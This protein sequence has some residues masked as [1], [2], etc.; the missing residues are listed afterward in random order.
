M[1]NIFDKNFQ[2]I[3]TENSLTIEPENETEKKLLDE[4][5]KNVKNKVKNLSKDYEDI[6]NIPQTQ[7]DTLTIKKGCEEYLT[8]KTKTT[9]EKNIIKLKQMTEYLK[10]YFGD[11]KLIKQITPIDSNNFRNFLL[12]VPK[13]YK[14]QNELKDKN[15]KVLIEK[16]SKI[17][18]KY[19]KQSLRTVDEVIKRV[20]SIF[21]YFEDV[22]Y[23]YKNPFVKVEKLKKGKKTDWK[24]FNKRELKPIFK[25]M[26]DNN[27]NEEFNFYKF[28]LMT[29]TRRG[30]ILD[31]K[32]K[33]IDLDKDIID[34]EGTKTEFSKRIIPIHKDLKNTIIK[35]ME[36]K[37][38]NDYLFFDFDKKLKSRVEK[39]GSR[40]NKIIIDVLGVENKKGLNIHS[41]RKNFS[42]EIFLSDLF[43]EID[44]KTIIG[45]STSGDITDEHYLRGKR[46]YK[47]YKE[48]IDKIDFKHYYN[49]KE[50]DLKD[51]NNILNFI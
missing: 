28:G 4:I 22:G 11:K 18:E 51:L 25:Y 7:R 41:L 48:K 14:G 50:N 35:Q 21:N 10:L 3:R 13:N 46:N 8:F 32:I 38:F 49:V 37:D 1:I 34:L 31:L 19:E 40:L 44:Y 6:K 47:D 27:L 5:E 12:E 2:Y 24:E 15:I 30:E 33:N 43:K 36:N 16:K 9:S 42:Q 39:W 23:I 26:Y 20:K 29:G 45:H 17:L